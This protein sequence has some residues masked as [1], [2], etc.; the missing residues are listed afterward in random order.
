MSEVTNALILAVYPYLIGGALLAAVFCGTAAW[1]LRDRELKLWWLLVAIAIIMAEVAMEN[2][3]FL[4]ARLADGTQG[5][6]EA[7]I[8]AASSPVLLFLKMMAALGAWILLYVGLAVNWERY[9]VGNWVRRML[10][11]GSGLFAV[12]YPLVALL[13]YKI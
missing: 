9:P 12:S 5:Q 13:V 1:R 3:L 8:A 6:W 4:I 2:L 11:I 7:L 10:F